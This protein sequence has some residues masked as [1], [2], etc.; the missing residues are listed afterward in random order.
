M[1]K[2]AI[3][4]GATG[5]TGTELLK[6]LLADDRY[7][8][9]KL[10]SRNSV[11]VSHPKVKEYLIDLFKLE[12]Y[13]ADFTADVVFC[14]IGTTK[15]KTPDENTYHKIDY[16]I[17]V[18]AARL[19]MVNNIPSFIVISAVG[20]SKD[21]RFFYN[22]TKAEMQEAVLAQHID[23][24]YILQPSLILASRADNRLGEKIGAAVMTL[25]NPLLWGNLAKYRSIKASTIAK[26]MVWLDN[27]SYD[28]QI[29]TSD[30]IVQLGA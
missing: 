26:A 29:I 28:K 7:E 22:R 23:N 8:K 20:V 5:S 10:F 25:L 9:V 19:A 12:D 15:A 16:G 17:P 2:T 30:K 11:N 18:A 13:A 24:T 27:N 6:L 1:S 3:I 4:L 14:C 21:S